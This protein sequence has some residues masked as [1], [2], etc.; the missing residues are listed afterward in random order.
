MVISVPTIY[1]QV[2]ES[3]KII[4]V[5]LGIAI[6][7]QL[8]PKIPIEFF[9][10]AIVASTAIVILPLAVSISS[11]AVSRI[12]GGSKI[13]GKSYFILGISYMLF[14]I[15][16]AL[17]Y[18]Y[19]DPSGNYEHRIWAEMMFMFSTPLLITHIIINIRYFAEKLETYQK[20]LLVVI[21]IVIVSGYG[22]VLLEAYSEN[23]DEYLFN[24]LV[25]AQSAASLGFIIV[26]FTVFRQ[27]ALFVPWFLLLIGILFG[28]TGDILYRYT[29]TISFYDFADPATGLWLASSMMVIYALYKHQK[30]I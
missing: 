1:S 8:S 17:F 3:Y 20:I 21:P 27:T 13:F 12:Y 26:A 10:S 2:R 7:I 4:L 29:D 22:M 5:I 30:S 16:E 24:L 19:M 23:T 14:F 25:I 9:E 6:A 11:F 15:G 18:F 28:T